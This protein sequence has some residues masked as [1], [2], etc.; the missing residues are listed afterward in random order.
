MLAAATV[1]TL[2]AGPVIQSLPVL[3]GNAGRPLSAYVPSPAL[4]DIPLASLPPA[5]QVA[6]IQAPLLA[7]SE[8]AAAGGGFTLAGLGS[9]ALPGL[10]VVL[11][12]ALVA[13]IGA[14]NIRVWQDRLTAF[15]R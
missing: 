5:Y 2:P 8:D 15:R 10:L 12:T 14:A 13:S 6:A 9:R 7:A 11:A 4:A 3:A 1:A